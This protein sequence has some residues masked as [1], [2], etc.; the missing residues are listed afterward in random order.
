MGKELMNNGFERSEE[1]NS[2]HVRALKPPSRDCNDES[3]ELRGNFC[4]CQEGENVCSLPLSTLD[5][6]SFTLTDWMRSQARIK[7]RFVFG[8]WAMQKGKEHSMRHQG[9]S[10]CLSVCPSV[11]LSVWIPSQQRSLHSSQQIRDEKVCIAPLYS[12][13]NFLAVH[14]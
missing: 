13:H 6:G 11:S 9:L 7:K 12:C 3:V 8:C 14:S 2:R 4:M 5:P 1:T 10:L